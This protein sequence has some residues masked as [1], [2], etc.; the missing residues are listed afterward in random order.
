MQAQGVSFADWVDWQALHLPPPSTGTA[1]S[2]ALD[3]EMAE[4]PLSR[5]PLRVKARLR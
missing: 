5:S 4:S 1:I 2:K 3:S